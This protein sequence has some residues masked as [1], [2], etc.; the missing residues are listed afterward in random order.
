M[1]FITNNILISTPP[2]LNNISRNKRFPAG[3]ARKWFQI[4]L[5]R[6]YRRENVRQ[7]FDKLRLRRSDLRTYTFDARVLM[8]FFVLCADNDGN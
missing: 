4:H 6:V 2:P 1:I 7:Y 5:D 8:D 3:R